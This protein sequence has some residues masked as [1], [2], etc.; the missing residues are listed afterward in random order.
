MR[1]LFW[2]S[3]WEEPADRWFPL[4]FSNTVYSG[5]PNLR[6]SVG[7]VLRRAKPSR[8]RRTA[9]PVRAELAGSALAE[10]GH[11]RD[12]GPSHF[13]RHRKNA[14]GVR[15]ERPTRLRIAHLPAGQPLDMEIGLRP[16][17]DLDRFCLSGR[18]PAIRLDREPISPR[19]KRQLLPD[20][21][22]SGSRWRKSLGPRLGHCHLPGQT[23]V[24]TIPE[25]FPDP[26][27][28]L[29]LAAGPGA[30]AGRSR[31]AQEA[32]ARRSGPAWLGRLPPNLTILIG[33]MISSRRFHLA[34]SRAGLPAKSPVICA[35]ATATSRATKCQSPACLWRNNRAVGYHGLSSRS[36]S[37]RQSGASPPH[38][39]AS[40]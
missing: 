28:E 29:V 30:M 16:C 14:E 11:C 9:A 18:Q 33:S 8:S 3:A 2:C 6:G 13:R 34:V 40:H 21:G 20:C 38:H 32:R 24:E 36:N 19:C 27:P 31:Q 17:S 7:V 26:R 37:H 15:G 35:R 12:V 1:T 4:L 5:R 23:P 39:R 10:I 22:R 25:R